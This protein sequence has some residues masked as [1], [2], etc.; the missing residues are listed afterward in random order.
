M[1]PIDRAL[2]NISVVCVILNGTQHSRPSH[3]SSKSRCE[4]EHEWKNVVALLCFCSS[5]LFVSG[6]HLKLKGGSIKCARLPNA[7]VHDLHV[8]ERNV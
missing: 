8:S 2:V 4:Q 7:G 6:S 5:P 3:L 1:S